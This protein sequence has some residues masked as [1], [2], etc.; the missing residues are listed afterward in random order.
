MID[1]FLEK[2]RV[3]MEPRSCSELPS[4]KDYLYQVK[5]D[6]I[7]MIAFLDQ[8]KV[9]LFNKHLRERTSQYPELHDLPQRID[10][11]SAVLDGEIVVLRDGKPNF[12]DV[13][14]RANCIINE[15]IG[16]MQISYPIEYILFDLLYLNGQN[17]MNLPLS[18]RQI[19]L[20]NIAIEKDYLHLVENFPDGQALF[21]AVQSMDMEGVVA[22]KYS[23][24]YIQGKKHRFWLKVKCL[25]RQNCLL[26]GYTLRG[27]LVNSLLLGAYRDGSLFYIGKAANGL[28]ADSQ[29]VLSQQLPALEIIDS[30]F[31]NISRK[32]PEMHFIKPELGLLVEFLEWTDDLKLRSP[33]I[34]NFAIIERETCV[35]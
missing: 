11:E 20:P 8:G 18:E 17:L 22:K 19:H 6:G 23:S 4:G 35:F 13:M 3:P 33:V 31:V 34:K 1:S 29:E 9:R 10:A 15:Q 28:D 2:F 14:R 24:P 27:K 32:P 21:K 12:P 7:R 25:R 30:P 5:W 26:G 16:Q